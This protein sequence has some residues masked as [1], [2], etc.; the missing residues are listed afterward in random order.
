[1]QSILIYKMELKRNDF[2]ILSIQ[3]IDAIKRSTSVD[4]W[5][6]V[7]P[8]RPNESSGYEGIRLNL[9]CHD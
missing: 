1:M 4:H 5:Q 3:K 7:T 2:Y 9:V 8:R 6:F